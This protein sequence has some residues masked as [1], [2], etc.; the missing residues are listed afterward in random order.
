MTFSEAD[1]RRTVELVARTPFEPELWPNVLELLSKAGGGWASQILGYHPAVGTTFDLSNGV[2]ELT[3]EWIRYG[4]LDPILN[5]RA[6][7]A[8]RNPSFEVLGENAYSR[9]EERLRSPIFQEFFSKVDAP[10]SASSTFDEIGG[11]RVIACVT[12]TKS[13]GYVDEI[14]AAQLAALLPHVGSALRLQHRLDDLGASVAVGAMGALHLCCLLVDRQARLVDATAVA[15]DLLRQGA[16]VRLRNGRLEASD[17]TSD[18]DLQA[19]IGEAA[20]RFSQRG[21]N[22]SPISF[23]LQSDRMK[24]WIVD[25]AAL[26]GGQYPL[27]RA[28]IVLVSMSP[29]GPTRPLDLLKRAYGLS[30]TEAEVARLLARG[31][32]ISSIAAER[33]VAVETVRNQVKAI[34]AKLSVNTQTDLVRLVSLVIGPDDR[35]PI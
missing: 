11:V 18:R 21:P 16:P 8:L 10:F 32:R 4:G 2:D 9:E 3:A 13:Q 34:F 19:A 30:G 29:S 12:R 7:S 6:R 14:S 28:G 31:E 5:P 35:P 25:V 26:P 27:A 24:S 1:Y 20:M 33:G 17:A 22:P 23:V 15:T